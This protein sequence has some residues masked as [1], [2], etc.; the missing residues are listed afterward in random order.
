MWRWL[1]YYV[2][3]NVGIRIVTFKNE[4]AIINLL[5]GSKNYEI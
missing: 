2:K 1:F 5:I 3:F 4:F